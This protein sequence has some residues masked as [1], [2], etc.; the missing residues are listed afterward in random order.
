MKYKIQMNNPSKVIKRLQLDKGGLTDLK[1]AQICA[2]RNDKYVPLRTGKLKNTV[3]VT[4]GKYTYIQKYADRQYRTNKG[5]GLRGAYWDKR[6]VS[7]EIGVI[8][9]EIQ[10]F[11]KRGV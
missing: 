9:R 8:T 2:R 11:I 4:P 1:L 6:M 3:M 7:A 5:K 10:K